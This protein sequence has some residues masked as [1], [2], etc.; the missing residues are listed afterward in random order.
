MKF[1]KKHTIIDSCCVAG[2]HFDFSEVDAWREA[3]KQR[4]EQLMKEPERRFPIIRID[5]FLDELVDEWLA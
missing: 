4:I 5:L 1:P 2:D 3:L